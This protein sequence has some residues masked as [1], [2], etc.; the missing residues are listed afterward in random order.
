MRI[1]RRDHSWSHTDL[2]WFLVPTRITCKEHYRQEFQFPYAQWLRR[3]AP[4]NT[5]CKAQRPDNGILR[6]VVRVHSTV[7]VHSI[8]Q[9]LC[10]EL[11]P[12]LHVP[13]TA[14]SETVAILEQPAVVLSGRAN[15]LAQQIEQVLYL[16]NAACWVPARYATSQLRECG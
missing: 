7:R 1:V 9:G 5:C 12:S 15:E 14:T 2:A 3:T 4:S 16:R 10:L 8:V 13:M 6:E 11:C